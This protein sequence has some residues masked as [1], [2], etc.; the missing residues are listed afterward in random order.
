[1][2]ARFALVLFILFGFIISGTISSKDLGI[3]SFAFWSFLLLF[4]GAVL[5]LLRK[6]L[7]TGKQHVVKPE[8]TTL[9]KHWAR[10]KKFRFFESSNQLRHVDRLGASPA[11]EFFDAEIMMLNSDDGPFAE[12]DCSRRKMW[13][14]PIVG[15]AFHAAMATGSRSMQSWREKTSLMDNKPDEASEVF[16]I[17]RAWCVEISH[18]KIPHRIIITS[19]KMHGPDWLDTESRDFEHDYDVSGIR[20]SE[21]LQLLDPAMI[22][23]VYQSHADAIEISDGSTVLYDAQKE[24]TYDTLD[25]FFE[26]APRIAKQVEQNFPK[27]HI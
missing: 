7:F 11:K 12:G 21:V 15:K 4:I 8:E 25:R 13:I 1:M 23:L 27:A 19:K 5:F 20:E 22:D 26:Y 17:F 16:L 18:K 9:L 10:T 2:S 24:L 3:P 6:H 14:Y